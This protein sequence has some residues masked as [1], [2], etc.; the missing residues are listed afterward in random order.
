MQKGPREVPGK[1]KVSVIGLVVD[2]STNTTVRLYILTRFMCTEKERTVLMF[3]Y[4]VKHCLLTKEK[5]C[6]SSPALDLAK[7]KFW[8][9]TKEKSCA[10]YPALDLAK[11]KFWWLKEISNFLLSTWNLYFRETMF[12]KVTLRD[13]WLGRWK[14]CKWFLTSTQN[15]SALNYAQDVG[16]A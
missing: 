10:S 3:W 9:L 16:I 11:E 2:N 5:S 13:F 12:V 4:Q 7:N 15:I 14:T 1:Q 8:W 6:L